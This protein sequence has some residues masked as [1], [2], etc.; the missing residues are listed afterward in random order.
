MKN[1]FELTQLGREVSKEYLE[2]GKAL[3]N[4]LEKVATAQG[5]TREEIKRVAEQAN[6]ETYLGLVDRV[7]DR[8]VEF[9]LAD[10]NDVIT[11]VAASEEPIAEPTLEEMF[12]DIPGIEFSFSMYKTTPRGEEVITK[13]ASD[14]NRITNEIYKVQDLLKFA[15]DTLGVMFV[16]TAELNDDIHAE[17]KQYLLSGTSFADVAEIVKFASANIAD[18]YIPELQD[19]MKNI[20]SNI[21]FEKKAS[22]NVMPNVTSELYKSLMGLEHNLTELTK[23]ANYV[24]HLE[25]EVN[26]FIKENTEMPQIKL[27]GITQAI[28]EKIK[29]YP[30][31]ST[32]LAASTG[33][34][35]AGKDIQEQR[36][37]ETFSKVSPEETQRILYNKS[38]AR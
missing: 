8:Y 19:D 13:V 15:E 4:T 10:A 29:K 3:N 6:V 5:L 20:I 26:T 24:L 38:L 35:M 7:Q 11:K 1:P 28:V 23:Q 25:N 32:A 37:L 18:E 31:T 36:D 9:E 14:S 27:A 22:E 21:D 2:N 33:G 16:K 34:Y 30:K 17:V 12:A